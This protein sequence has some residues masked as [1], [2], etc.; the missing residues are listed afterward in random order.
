MKRTFFCCF[1]LLLFSSLQST[2]QGYKNPVLPGFYPDP[3]VCRAGEYYYLVNSSF[4]Y[5]PAVP[6]HRSKDLINWESIGH[7]LSRPTQVKLEKINSWGGIY[8]PTI[9]YHKGRFY[10]IT[11]NVS[12]KGNFYVYT[13]DPAGEWSEPIWVDQGGIDPD[14][15]FNEDGKVYFVSADRGLVL[16]EIDIK[17]GKRLT[18]SKVIWNGTGGRYPE[19]PHIYKKDG[20]YYL[21]IAE[22]GTE[23]GHKVTIARSRSLDGPFESNPA[24]PILT[25]INDIARSNPIQGTGHADLIQAHDGSWWTV[26]LGF[27]P[28]SYLHHVLGR[29]TFLAPVS[30]EENLW[31]VVNTNGTVS[32]NMDVRTLPQVKV[33]VQSSKENFNSSRPGNE[34]NYICNPTSANYSLQE[35][36]G[37]LRLKTSTISLNDKD[38]P[39]FLGRRQQHSSFSAKTVIDFSKLSEGAKAGI[40]SYMM[41]DYHYDLYVTIRNKRPVLCLAYTLGSLKQVVKE[42]SLAE[43]QVYLK[44]EGTND[45]YHFFYSYQG[46]KFDKMG[47]LDVR[48]LSSET[49]GGFTGVYLGLFAE[50]SDKS[51]GYADFDWFD[52]VAQTAE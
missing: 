50:S 49:A 22:G 25:H 14:I 7:V 21:M 29:E 23:Y 4:Q 40:T 41:N 18:E 6:I 48:F 3:S 42:I 46:R 39:T 37:H 33:P 8:A 52:Y 13:D 9:R 47:S 12:D 16:C 28:Q 35:R 19:G 27:R 30:W 20:Y 1:L 31:P 32:L 5:F 17:T 26:F 43:K 38:S 15:F 51:G 24:N 44:I 11:T 10:M 2:G 45:H 34:W 36:K